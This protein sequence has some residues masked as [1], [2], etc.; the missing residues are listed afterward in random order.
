MIGSSDNASEYEVD[1]LRLNQT[2][3][4]LSSPPKKS[5]LS[6]FLSNRHGFGD[7]LDETL[8][9]STKRNK[10]ISKRGLIVMGASVFIGVLSAPLAYLLLV[11]ISIISNICFFGRFSI[12]IVDVSTNTLGPWVILIPI[13]G[14]VFVG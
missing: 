10:T 11:L 12:D 4:V 6:R 2:I 5:L 9:I 14:A 13:V 8:W 1:I 7:D 3:D